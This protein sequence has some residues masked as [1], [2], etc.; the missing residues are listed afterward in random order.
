MC[1]DVLLDACCVVGREGRQKTEPG[2]YQGPAKRQS[3]E[4]GGLGVW[5]FVMGHSSMVGGREE[6]QAIHGPTTDD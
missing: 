4:K 5:D 3:G 1:M 2:R 6:A